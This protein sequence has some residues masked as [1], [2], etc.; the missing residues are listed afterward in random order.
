MNWH[1]LAEMA[2]ARRIELGYR[3][4]DAFAHEAGVSSRVLADFENSRRTTYTAATLA[5]LEKTLRWR[6]GSFTAILAGGD[7]IPLD[8]RIDDEEAG[9]DLT[10][11]EVPTAVMIGRA[12]LP[13]PYKLVLRARLADWQAQLARDLNSTIARLHDSLVEGFR[14]TNQTEVELLVW[15]CTPEDR[16]A[17]GWQMNVL[18]ASQGTVLVGQASDGKTS[19]LEALS[20][21]GK[22]SIPAFTSPARLREYKPE[23]YVAKSVPLSELIAELPDDVWAVHLNPGSPISFLTD[24]GNLRDAIRLVQGYREESVP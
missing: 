14:P 24:P 20:D 10:V 4:R 7:P 13:A 8:E 3:T 2:A 16:R 18:L 11:D 15:R 1:R 23:G 6:A 21:K 22:R 12:R 9:F 17:P 19:A 5:A